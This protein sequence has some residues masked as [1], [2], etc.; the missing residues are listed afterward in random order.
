[1]RC[2]ATT[3]RTKH[4]KDFVVFVYFVVL[5]V[6][7]AFGLSL[8]SVAAHNPITTKVTWTRE[9]SA[10]FERRCVSCHRPGGYAGFSLTTYADARPW[11]VAIKEEVLAGSMPPWG[12]A[13]GIGHFAN[14]RRLTRHEQELIAA[15][16]DG[17]APYS[18]DARTPAF[19]TSTP[20]PNSQRP[21]PK[22][23]TPELLAGSVAIPLAP[24]TITE[25]TERTASVTLQLPAGL[26]LT[27]WTF[28]PGIPFSVERVDLELGS[29]WVGTW[30]PGEA[31]LTFPSDTGVPLTTSA[32]FT[33]QMR[34]RAQS[35]QPLDQSF[36]RVWM[37]KNPRPK[38]VREVMVVRNWRTTDSV[39]LLAMRPTRDSDDLQVLARFANGRT[40]AIAL[41]TTPSRGPHP[42]YRLTR[43]L[44]LPAGARIETTGPVRLL[45]S[46][47]ATR[48]VKPNVRRRPRR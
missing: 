19:A 26:S 43:P 24:A 37:D 17:G 34:Y 29:R 21:T 48:T 22:A 39:E 10:I 42:T 31:R 7:V 5:A 25:A 32:L 27:A 28:E 3:K 47:A 45:Y 36:I 1:V 4:T 38:D 46:A 35:T 6:G 30:T 11:A 18:L 2:T 9:V 8:E 41:L 20:T 13:P 16:V 33:A 14:D 44:P 40:E 15:W 23:I 12:A